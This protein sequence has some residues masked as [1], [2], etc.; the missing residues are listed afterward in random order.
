ML[1]APIEWALAGRA[2]PATVSV[3][4]A[5][6]D[7]VPDAAA[8]DGLAGAELERAARF[9][10]DRDRRRFLAARRFMR[11]VLADRLGCAAGELR[12]VAGEHGKPAL[13]DHADLYFNLAHSEA[14]ALLVL[15]PC[16]VGIDVELLRPIADA[17]LLAE[18]NYTARERRWIGAAD[19]AERSR[20]FLHCW[21]RKEACL[22]A[23]GCGLAVE[24]ASFDVLAGSGS[25]PI[26]VSWQ[27]RS[28]ELSVHQ[29]DDRQGRW[30]AAV[31]LVDAVRDDRAATQTNATHRSVARAGAGLSAAS[32]WP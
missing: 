10:F 18:R 2:A 27:A 1:G 23:V 25:A 12:L 17:E 22:K 21:T 20:R 15:A 29:I 6:L 14:T 13:A 28:F 4:H 3:W 24:P 11:Q 7:A 31:A 32:C 5:N 30:V 9:V 8:P 26:R 19:G 16:A